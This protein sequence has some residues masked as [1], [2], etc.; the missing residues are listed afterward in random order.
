MMMTKF[1]LYDLNESTFEEIM[2]VEAALAETLGPTR[3]RLDYYIL[4]P[5]I[6]GEKITW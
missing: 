4:F 6:L 2:Y 3:F 1:I 5:S